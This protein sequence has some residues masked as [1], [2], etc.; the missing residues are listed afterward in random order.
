MDV[1]LNKVGK[2]PHQP[3]AFAGRHFP[4]SPRAIFERLAGGLDCSVNV[5]GR[6]VDHSGQHLA[7]CGIDCLE[8]FRSFQPL[9]VD[10]H[11]S[12][13]DFCLCC[14][15]VSC[16]LTT[17]LAALLRTSQQVWSMLYLAVNVAGR[18]STYA[19][20]PSLASSLWNSNCW[21]SRSSA[22]ADSIGI[23]HP[24]CTARLILPTALAALLGGQNCRA[25]SMTLSMN[26]SRSK[27]SFTIPSSCASSKE[28]VFPVTINSMALLFPT[29]RDR[30]CVPPVPGRT[31]RLTSGSPIFPASLRAMRMSAAMAIS[32]PP[33]TV[34]PLSAA[35]TSLGVCS[36]RS[37]VSLACKQK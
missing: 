9:A 10:Q 6:R 3:P 1:F 36:S 5:P 22:N 26:P 20:K 14:D 30:R 29:S 15:H 8:R 25:Y 18:F 19:A 4:P 24:D 23:S 34:C 17:A 21:F 13:L 27:M 12:R 37:S 11:P 31:P 7:G 28:K 32:N 16:S 35:I 33:P 2:F